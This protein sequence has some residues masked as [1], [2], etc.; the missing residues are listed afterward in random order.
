MIHGPINEP[1]AQRYTA[2]VAPEDVSSNDRQPYPLV[3]GTQR[4]P[5]MWI[6]QI[7]DQRTVAVK[8]KSGGKKGK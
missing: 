2:N 4:V 1:P 3:M 6:G 7:W 8:Q 5:L